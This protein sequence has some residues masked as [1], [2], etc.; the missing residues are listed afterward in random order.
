MKTPKLLS[1]NILLYTAA[2]ERRPIAVFMDEECIGTGY[3]EEIDDTCIR[4][5]GADGSNYFLRANCTLF[6]V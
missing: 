4:I 3:I 2:I 5:T 1:S 6:S